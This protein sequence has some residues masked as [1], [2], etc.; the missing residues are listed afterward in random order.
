MKERIL[1]VDRRKAIEWYEK[2]GDLRS[3]A[4][5]IYEEYELRPTLEEEIDKSFKGSNKWYKVVNMQL[6]DDILVNKTE[7]RGK[8]LWKFMKANEFLLKASVYFNKGWYKRTNKDLES[9]F[10]IKKDVPSK[11]PSQAW[12]GP[13]TVGEHQRMTVAGTVYFKNRSDAIRVMKHMYATGMLEDLFS[14]TK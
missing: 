14:I 7:D 1:K 6:Y 3:L 13:F 8:A 4:L 11:N 10:F 9:G 5:S 2:G 12:C